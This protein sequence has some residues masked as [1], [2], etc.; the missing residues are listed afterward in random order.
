VVTRHG[1]EAPVLGAI[2][3]VGE[4][5]D[6]TPIIVGVGAAYPT[7]QSGI[8]AASSG[9]LV[10]VKAGLYEELVIM[11]KPVRLQAVG[12]YATMI[13]AIKFPSE[14]LLNWRNRIAAL[15]DNYFLPGQEA[16]P[17]AGGPDNEPVLFG[18]EEGAGITVV[19]PATGP[20]G[21][22]ANRPSRISGFWITGGD[23][24][25]A[26]Y[27]NGN[28]RFLEISNNRITSNAG[29]YG[30]GIRVGH[31]TLVVNDTDYVDANNQQIDIHHNMVTQNGAMAGDGGG[32][33]LYS[34]SHFYE[35]TDNFICGNIAQ[36][37]GGGIAHLGL[38]KNGRIERNTVVFNESF[39]QGRS[40]SG[41]GIFVGGAPGLTPNG[42]SEGSGI[43]TINANRIQ[44]NVAG[45]GDGGGI[46]LQQVNGQDV[47][48]SPNDQ[49]NWHFVFISNNFIV[50]N[51]TGLAGGGV[52]L[53]DAL[54]V[55]MAHN[56]VANN[57]STATA[58]E[59]FAPGSPNASLSQP[60]AGL[61]A[62]QHSN[63]LAAAI[64]PGAPSGF[65]LGFPNP[66]LR[67]NIFWHNRSFFWETT[68]SGFRLVP[69]V[70][71]GQS[72][73]YDDLAVL[74]LSLGQ[75]NPQYSLMTDPT[76]YHASNQTPPVE[77]FFVNEVVNGDRQATV[78][79]PEATTSIV[80]APAFDEGGNFIDLNYGPLTLGDSDYHLDPT[81]LCGFGGCFA[82]A[83]NGTPIGGVVYETDVDGQARPVG[84][85]PDMG[86]D[87][88][89]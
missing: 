4:P 17:I 1:G 77:P 22:N 60:G 7:I 25:G 56:T 88:L 41:G 30:G 81:K 35:V 31:P 74:P 78:L 89:Q 42:L 71:A 43:V 28:A 51:V 16:G 46:R 48:A 45:A 14:K 68:T 65:L 67:N 54:R 63:E 57:D 79:Q 58:G 44:G 2:V 34:G 47:A 64:G 5:G 87:E 9:D 66:F 85:G 83:E 33:A 40:V 69:D 55:N 86:A 3:T 84:N 24:A 70:G 20:N 75:L 53:Q 61:V 27:V 26:I 15:P 39:T 21:F 76:G 36:G 82:P 12:A 59:A 38:S 52:S 11:D 49:T 19:A 32:I 73:I 18:T 72:P 29:V 6:S 23:D 80:P 10:L 37:N 13:N 50:N 8:D 62:R